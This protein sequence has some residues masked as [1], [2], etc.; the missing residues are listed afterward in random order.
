[1]K[2]LRCP[3]CDCE[4]DEPKDIRVVKCRRCGAS[5]IVDNG[6]VYENPGNIV[7]LFQNEDG[8]ERK[9]STEEE[10]RR[11][12]DAL[13]PPTPKLFPE[14]GKMGLRTILPIAGIVVAMAY[15]LWFFIF[16]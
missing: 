3:A 1:M 14:P 15:L 12:T 6:E 10:A 11:L 13:L 5:L 16:R 4:F 9:P 8:S 2:T 7:S